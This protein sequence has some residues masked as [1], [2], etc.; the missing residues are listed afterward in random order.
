MFAPPKPAAPAGKGGPPSAP[1]AAPIVIPKTPMQ[2][3]IEKGTD[4]PLG[5]PPG[6][7]L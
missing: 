7:P 2:I 5:P 6:N 4:F 1:A 3:L